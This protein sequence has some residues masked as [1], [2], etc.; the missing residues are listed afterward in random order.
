MSRAVSDKPDGTSSI[1][2]EAE[3][4]KNSDVETYVNSETFEA[5]NINEKPEEKAEEHIEDN[6][7]EDIIVPE[8]IEKVTEAV[9]EEEKAEESIALVPISSESDIATQTK[10]KSTLSKVKKGL[11][12]VAG[13]IASI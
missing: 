6:K 10:K 5:T 1:E 12:T 3:N 7:E 9:K 13:I 11:S 2:N 4:I 8:I